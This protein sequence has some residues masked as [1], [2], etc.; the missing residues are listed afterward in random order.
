MVEWSSQHLFLPHSFSTQ[1]FI[2][3]I[4][5]QD[6]TSKLAQM[7]HEATYITSV[8]IWAGVP[9]PYMCEALCEHVRACISPCMHA[10][11][12]GMAIH[13][14]LAGR[15]LWQT[16]KALYPCCGMALS[17][18]RAPAAQQSVCP[19][20]QAS[21]PVDKM[22]GWMTTHTAP[23]PPSSTLSGVTECG[24]VC[25]ITVQHQSHF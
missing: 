21:C 18:S 25:C 7:W 22:N 23:S 19:R 24:R 13:A 6:F 16:K 17:F 12:A 9:A 14:F 11:S 5:L 3:L 15:H 20:I 4:F 2:E 1:S 8:Y 10:C